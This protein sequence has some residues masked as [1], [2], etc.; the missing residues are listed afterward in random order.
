M[1]YFQR[2]G[3]Y[4]G[5]MRGN[6]EAQYKIANLMNQNADPESKDRAFTWYKNSADQG[7]ADACMYMVKHSIRVN[8][9]SNAIKYLRLSL[10]S[11]NGL[12]ES[13]LGQILLNGYTQYID[14]ERLNNGSIKAETELDHYIQSLYPTSL[15]SS[16]LTITKDTVTETL[17]EALAHLHIGIEKQNPLALHALA[18]YTLEYKTDKS[19]EETTQAVKWLT[20]ASNKNF[21]PSQQV[22]AGIY[23]NGLYG[24]KVNV[25]HGLKLRL[26]AAETGS[27]EAQFSLGILVYKGNGFQQNRA[28][29]KKLIKMAADQGHTEAIE[30][31]KNLEEKTH[32]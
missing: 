7:H 14:Q 11:S 2:L 13:L 20:H 3:A 1:N 21:A 22:L 32:G 4:F 24:Y 23:E 26:K 29:G 10:P 28:E 31:L 25:E 17:N 27:K 15:H 9:I 8:D 19:K 16:Q 30:F 18:V 5:A 6:P 12:S